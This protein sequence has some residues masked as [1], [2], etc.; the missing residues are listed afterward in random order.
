MCLAIPGKILDIEELSGI[1]F[2]RVEFG[3]ILRQTCLDLV[4]DA[5]PGDYV[6]VHVG[7]ALTKV[8][9]AEA[10]RTLELMERTGLIAEE[11]GPPPAPD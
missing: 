1:R 7:V 8:D 5:H 6:L 9:E 2:G 3:G 11:L 4:P 10:A